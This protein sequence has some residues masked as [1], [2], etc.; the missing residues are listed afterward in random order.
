MTTARKHRYIWGYLTAAI[1]MLVTGLWGYFLHGYMIYT[2]VVH[3][4][5]VSE[6]QEQ[7]NAFDIFIHHP[8]RTLFALEFALGGLFA[9]SGILI[10]LKK[11]LGWYLHYAIL[12]LS[13]LV[14]LL[15]TIILISMRMSPAVGVP[16]GP[17]GLILLGLTSVFTLF[18]FGLIWFQQRY[19]QRFL[20]RSM[21]ARTT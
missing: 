3:E 21:A 7:F 12:T 15:L 1:T 2:F 11:P 20:Q 10:A 17:P 16:T 13:G 8:Y 9:L 4:F 5:P 19:W 6:A 18:F 14:L